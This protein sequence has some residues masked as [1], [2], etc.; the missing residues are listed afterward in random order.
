[1]NVEGACAKKIINHGR[2]SV[3]FGP[4]P[5]SPKRQHPPPSA[6][7]TWTTYAFLFESYESPAIQWQSCRLINLQQ[8]EHSWSSVN[9][10]EQIIWVCHFNLLWRKSSDM[11]GAL[12]DFCRSPM[13]ACILLSCER[14]CRSERGTSC[15]KSCLTKLLGPCHMRHYP[16]SVPYEVHFS[17]CFCT[18]TRRFRGNCCE[19]FSWQ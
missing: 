9:S 13:L 10:D 11:I 2:N 14:L 17:D 4:T 1:M 7:Q 16:W 5:C 19:Y 18:R 15:N 6:H 3:P 12:V 8:H